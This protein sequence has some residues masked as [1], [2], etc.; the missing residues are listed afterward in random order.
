MG[1]SLVRHEYVYQAIKDEH[2]EHNYPITD[3][4]KLG[5]VSRAAYYKWL[6]REIPENERK[7]KRIADEI[8]KDSYGIAGQRISQNQR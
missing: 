2:E 4:C 1:L 5:R 7:N 6:H 8:E 3:L